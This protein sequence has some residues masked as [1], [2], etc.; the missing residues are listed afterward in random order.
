M[1][2]PLPTVLELWVYPVKSCQGISLQSS[3][4]TRT[5]L[6]YD[7]SFA[8]FDEEGTVQDIRIH[9]KLC[10]L[11]PRFECDNSGNET[12]LLLDSTAVA[13]STLRVPLH[14]P[15]G[16]KVDIRDRV[17]DKWWGGALAGTCCGQEAA[18]WITKVLH[19]FA[20]PTGRSKNYRLV[21]YSEEQ[22]TRRLSKAFA[23][24]SVIAKRAS[25]HDTASFADCAP[26]HLVSLESLEDLNDRLASIGEDRVTVH[27]FRPNIVV[28]GVEEPYKEDLWNCVCTNDGL[29]EVRFRLLGQTGRCVIPTTHPFTGIRDT[30]E[31]PRELLKSYRPMP[32]G[33][34]VHGGPTLGV[35]LACDASE[36]NLH[37]GQTIIVNQSKL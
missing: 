18:E 37:V 7:R 31:Q 17:G 9:P 26:Y 19:H 12:H 23:G 11:R 5:G 25:R 3:K 2:A 22:D 1:G 6:Q 15:L 34:G 16:K 27:R 29:S 28:G 4:L 13:M 33:D 32:Y 30:N 20:S 36:G 10:T 24:K 35:W 8:V 14:G 21:R